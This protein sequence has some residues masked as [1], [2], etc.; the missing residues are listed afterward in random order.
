[1]NNNMLMK[2]LLAMVLA[3]VAGYLTGPDF[4]FFGVTFLEI[5]SLIG[6]LFLNALT[7]V[8]VP[9]VAASVITGTARMGAENSFGSLG[10]K[11]FGI[12]ALTTA[13]AIVVGWGVTMLV[14]PGLGHEISSYGSAFNAQLAAVQNMAG[15]VDTSAFHKIEL[16]LLK[17][18][19][20]NIL[21]V[22][23]Q[24]QMLGLIFFSLLFGYFI[25]KIDF[26]TGNILLRFWRGIFEVMMCMT[27]LV[28]KA[29]PIGVFG[30]MA[31]VVATTGFDTIRPI[32]YFFGTVI[33]A[34][35]VYTIVVLPLLLYFSG[36]NPLRHFKAMVPA[37]FTAFSTSSSAATLPIT[38]DCV[39]KRAGVSNRICSFTIPLAT[40]LNLSGTG[41][42][43][44]VSVLFICQVYGLELGFPLQFFVVLMSLLT[45][46]GIAGIPSASIVAIIMILQTIG[47][48]ADGIA[49]IL[50]VERLLDM[51]RTVVNVFGN[52]VCAVLIAKSEGEGNVLTRS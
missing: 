31:K 12:Y 25:P 7:L 8:V 35:L 41:L 32:S 49:L 51:C 30:L 4:G 33:L 47:L 24:G 17:L 42:Y 2:V 46:I 52:T 37:L 29:L 14:S 23:S 34:L 5:Y 20:S 3:V 48:P 38:I 39:E 26:E 1:M 43:I 40:S 21:A 27:H 9:L 16:I 18:V 50:A 22:A 10:L 45:S 44:C 36:V 28:M 6:Q 19:P 15:N 13:M 11:T